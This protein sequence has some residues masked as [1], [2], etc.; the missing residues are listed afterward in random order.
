MVYDY[1]KDYY[2][3]IA[4]FDLSEG[5]SGYTGPPR[6]SIEQAE[7]DTFSKEGTDALETLFLSE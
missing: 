7:K 2:K 3:F 5:Q 1:F 4:R 6:F